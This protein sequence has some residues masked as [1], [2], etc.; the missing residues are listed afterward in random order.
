MCESQTVFDPFYISTYNMFFTALPVI[1]LGTL[2]KDLGERLSL[3]FPEL[4]ARRRHSALN[5]RP[6]E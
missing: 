2:D 1:A 4:Y 5:Q 6:I 3:R